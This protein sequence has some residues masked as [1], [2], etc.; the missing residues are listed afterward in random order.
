MFN[1]MVTT[2]M[3]CD[4]WRK[5]ITR[6]HATRNCLNQNAQRIN[7][8]LFLLIKHAVTMEI[9]IDNLKHIK[10]ITSSDFNLIMSIRYT[11]HSICTY[12]PLLLFKQH[13]STKRTN[14]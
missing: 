1:N 2:I 12:I 5:S 7:Y 8:V 14:S 9:T 4:P 13:V 10:I 11:N 3:T 6:Q